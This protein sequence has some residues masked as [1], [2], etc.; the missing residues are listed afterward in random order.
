MEIVPESR[1]MTESEA[2][3]DHKDKHPGLAIAELTAPPPRRQNGHSERF[4]SR[5]GHALDGKRQYS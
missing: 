5:P 3:F 4:G 2:K 1:K